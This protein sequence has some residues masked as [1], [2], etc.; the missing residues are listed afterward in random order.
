MVGIGAGYY[1][2]K[3]KKEQEDQ[4]DSDSDSDDGELEEGE[5]GR[6]DDFSTRYGRRTDLT[7]KICVADRTDSA[8]ATTIPE[9]SAQ[10]FPNFVVCRNNNGYSISCP[11]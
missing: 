9:G 2:Y 3:K 5:K 11:L 10:Y 1:Y 6:A 4:N 8:S 7:R